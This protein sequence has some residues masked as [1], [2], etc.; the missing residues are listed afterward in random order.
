MK[1]EMYETKNRS[2][3]L[4]P[5]SVGRLLRIAGS[6]TVLSLAFS[7]SIWGQEPQ[8]GKTSFADNK[9]RDVN[10]VLLVVNNAIFSGGSSAGFSLSCNSPAGVPLPVELLSFTGKCENGHILMEWSTGS[11]TNNNFFTLEKLDDAFNWQVIDQ[12]KGAGNSSVILYYSFMDEVP[13]KGAITYRLTQTDYNGQVTVF[14]PIIVESCASAL[15]ELIVYPNPSLGQFT[16]S[17]GDIIG[18]TR[19]FNSLGQLVYQRLYGISFQEDIDLSNLPSAIYFIEVD[20]G[21]R[22]LRSKIILQ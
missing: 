13:S 11:E 3:L 19:I 8:Q 14:N 20:C 6:L 10:P 22:V 2:Y 16:I 1:Q 7:L 12:M 17:A 15:T 18:N 5:D 9:I 4:K 21:G